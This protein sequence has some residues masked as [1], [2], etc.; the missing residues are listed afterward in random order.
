M[1]GLPRREGLSRC[2]TDAKKA[3][4]SRCRIDAVLRMVHSLSRHGDTPQPYVP[5]LPRRRR[6]DHGGPMTTPRFIAHDIPD[7]LNALPTMF[8]FSPQESIVA[9]GTFGDRHRL[10]FSMRLDIPPPAVNP[11]VARTVAGHLGRQGAEGA[12]VLAVS[13]R[14]EVAGPLVRAVER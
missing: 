12:I 10:G 14:P 6:A 9:I 3:S 13:E 8:G 5:G 2:S 4:R 7:L 11:V 1:T